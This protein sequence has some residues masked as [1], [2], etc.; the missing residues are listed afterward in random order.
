MKHFSETRAWPYLLLLPSLV[1]VGAIVIYPTITGIDFS[2]RTLRLNRPDLGQ[3]YNDLRN[4]QQLL[5][6]PVFWLS[7]RNTAVWVIATV[8]IELGLGLLAALA[9]DFELPGFRAITVIVLLPWFMPIVVAGNIWALLLDS[10][11]GF[12][13]AAL[14]GIGI[15]DDF[16]P[17]FADPAWAMPAA[18]L[19]EAWHG[20]PFF[21]LLLLAGLKGVPGELYEAAAVDGARLWHRLI[22]IQ[23]PALRT[24]IVAAV[25]LR[26]ISLMNAPELILI[27]TGGGPG[28]STQVLS[29]YAFQNA[30]RE[31]NFG[32]A[33]ALS[34]VMFLLLML[35]AFLYVRAS[36]AL[37][38]A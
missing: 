9:L 37:R 33:G 18:I 22:H 5:D 4:Y 28:R 8:L 13:N 19:V 32:Y 15:L 30:Y 10:R 24:I 38:E 14:V 2:F 29:L 34:V 20:F 23:L 16:K 26:A 1:L 35:A 21:A 11:L 3:A 12:I 31:F 25:V 7:L 36:G 27:L 6:D 17:W